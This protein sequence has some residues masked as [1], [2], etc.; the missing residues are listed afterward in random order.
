[1]NRFDAMNLFVRVAEQGSFSAAAS[2]LGVARS[3]V[4]RQIAALEEHLGVKLMVRST[5]SLSLT[6]AGSAYLEKCRAILDLVQ[7]AEAG[8][9]EER[10]TPSGQLRVSLPLSFGLRR[11]VP[12]L[13]EFSRA[14]PEINL[15][16]DFNDRHLNLIEEGFDLSI[17][18]TGQLD[19]GVIARKLATC[20]LITV[21]APEYLARHGRPRHPAD[22]TEH[23]CMGYSPQANNRPLNF[24]VDGHMESFYRSYRLQANNGDVLAEAA[25]Q[26]LGITMQPDFIVDDY[27]AAGKLQTV[28]EDFE[29]PVLGI[30][31]VLPTNRYI[32]HRVRLLIEFLSNKLAGARAATE[33]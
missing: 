22:L 25:A 21:A 17:R 3:V 5:R 30:Y 20:R 14:Y 33:R 2:Q 12:L 6:S 31:A 7:E 19:P 32:P 18:I 29:P 9:M 11:L 28:L 10:L 8:V 15:A 24:Q 13:L 4:T 26:G 23:A 27:L 16:M 1:M